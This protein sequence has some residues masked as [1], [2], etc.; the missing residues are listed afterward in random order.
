MGTFVSVEYY[1]S[2]SELARLNEGFSLGF[3]SLLGHVKMKFAVVNLVG[4]SK[5][6]YLCP[7]FLNMRLNTESF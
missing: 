6:K 2:L 3:L 1:I 5:T 4:S 7:F